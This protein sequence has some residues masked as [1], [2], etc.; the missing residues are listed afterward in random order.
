M[1]PLRNARESHAVSHGAFALVTGND[2]VVLSG[3]AKHDGNRT[4]SG[5]AS[6]NCE[7]PDVAGAFAIEMVNARVQIRK[8]GILR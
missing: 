4:D 1:H 2:S 6:G 8:R 5:S 3:W 7:G